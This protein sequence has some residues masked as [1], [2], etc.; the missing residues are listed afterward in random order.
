MFS[1][2]HLDA[3]GVF[4]EVPSAVAIGFLVAILIFSLL[5]IYLIASLLAECASAFCG[6]FCASAPCYG[7]TE[8]IRRPGCRP[9][10]RRLGS[11][12]MDGFGW[13]ATAQPQL[14]KRAV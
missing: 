11:P 6:S 13:E 1:D 4:G 3:V 9:Y 8:D 12:R 10:R 14:S 5:I 7:R 2:R